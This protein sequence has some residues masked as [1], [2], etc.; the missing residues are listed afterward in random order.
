[1]CILKKML[2]LFL[3]QAVSKIVKFKNIIE[4]FNQFA[5]FLIH[6]SK[7]SR[8]RLIQILIFPKNKYF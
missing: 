8:F 1:M 2:Q 7:K 4:N 3:I 5:A 6:H